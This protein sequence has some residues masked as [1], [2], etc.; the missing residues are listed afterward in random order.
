MITQLFEIFCEQND[1]RYL[2]FQFLSDH[3]RIHL[4]RYNIIIML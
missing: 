2:V 4:T 1:F 3:S